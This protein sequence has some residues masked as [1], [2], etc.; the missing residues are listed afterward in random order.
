M[1]WM[2]RIKRVAHGRKDIEELELIFILALSLAL[3]RNRKRA[4]S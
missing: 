3:S 1:N 2:L 4:T